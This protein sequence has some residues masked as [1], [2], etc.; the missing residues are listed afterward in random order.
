MLGTV[1][2][3]GNYRL[4]YCLRS[5]CVLDRYLAMVVHTEETIAA[6]RA[7]LLRFS[8]LL[9]VFTNLYIMNYL[10]LLINQIYIEIFVA[11]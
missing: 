8:D 5:F 6:G 10:Q 4:L 9:K 11:T 1:H 7:K 2:D 3:S